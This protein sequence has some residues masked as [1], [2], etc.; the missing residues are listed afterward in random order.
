[1]R[2]ISCFVTVTLATIAPTAVSQETQSKEPH[3]KHPANRLAGESSPYL[4]LHAHN[5]VDWYPWGPEALEKARRENKPIFLSIGYSSCYWCHVMEREVFSNEKIAKYMNEHFV[6]IKL[7]REE[8][9]D[10]DDIYM[11]SLVIYLQATGN[12]GGGGWPMS[13]FLLPDGRPF[14][15]GTYF[16]AETGPRG[17]GFDTVSKRVV[18]LYRDSRPRVVQTAE[19]LT[20]SVRRAMKPKPPTSTVALSEELAAGVQDSLRRTFDSEYGGVNFNPGRP[21]GPKFPV[22]PKIEYLL[23]RAA[24]GN[25]SAA[26]MAFL[27][28]D[29]MLA[30][31][32]RDHLAGGFHRY[33]TDRKWHVP[34]FEK[35]LYDQAQ[36]ATVYTQAWLQTNN[37]NYR[38]AAT[39]ILNYVLTDF[40]D[41]L[42]G[43]YS[44]LDAETNT[45]E[46][47]YYVWD[48]KTIETVLGSDDAALFAQVYGLDAPNPFEHGYVLHLPRPIAEQTEELD[49]TEADLR[50]RLSGLKQ[51]LLAHRSEREAPLLDDKVLTSWNG[52]MIRA[53][54]DAATAF[55]SDEYRTAAAAAAEFILEKMTDENGRLLRTWRKKEAKLNAYLDDYAFFISGLLSLHSATDDP[56]WLRA[57]E[58]LQAKQD[59][60]FRAEE[61]GG[62]Y[63]TSH[64]HEELI[65]RTRNANDGVLPSGN[66]VSVRNLVRLA[67]ATGN[68]AYGELATETLTAFSQPLQSRSGELANMGLALFEH[69]EQDDSE[70]LRVS[71]VSVEHA[72]QIRTVEDKKDP[73][74]T[75]DKLLQAKAFLNVDKLPAGGK[76]RVAI[77]CRIRKGWHINAHK[78]QPDYLF[79]TQLEMK[80]KYGTK[81]TKL[82][83]PRHK[84]KR[85]EGEK[86]P[87]HLY[88]DTVVIYGE[89]LVP[90]KAIG[91]TEELTLTL[92]YQGC[93]DT[94]CLR[95]D[96]TVL[97]GKLQVVDTRLVKQINRDKFVVAKKPK[98][99]STRR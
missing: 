10:L 78:P 50:V 86:E 30:G 13:M 64:D 80:S 8:R 41:P 1:M 26:D 45:I 68:T 37:Q 84:V 93:D 59:E 34:H 73:K 97:F 36:L 54:A 22:P 28:L 81:L 98:T 74:K 65:V 77:F 46:G 11:T 2:T 95:P 25:K 15:G 24:A 92:K 5:P 72:M 19:L 48:R 76:A 44:A 75:K 43:F 38:E 96:K 71:R 33:S 42:G 70:G 49:L 66:S 7:D 99:G 88:E 4:L 67:A 31:G 18:E 32:I 27:T 47:E 61:S 87:Y 16:P 83:Y 17:I 40:T 82:Q 58:R 56:K 79:A 69:L 60:L 51:K 90:P 12:G 3:Q 55:D 14:A 94:T 29:N 23:H 63:F 35:M 91:K 89:V 39:E 21:E 53:F 52:L 62:Y 20:D 57:A 6:N 9:P 85:V